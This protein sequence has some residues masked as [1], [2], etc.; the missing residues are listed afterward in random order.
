[1]IIDTA[2]NRGELTADSLR[3]T[4]FGVELEKDAVEAVRSGK[5]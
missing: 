5:P 4:A 1:M 2:E 3:L